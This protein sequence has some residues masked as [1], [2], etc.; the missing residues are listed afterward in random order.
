MMM[1]TAAAVAKS[2]SDTFLPNMVM[3]QGCL[4]ILI[5]SLTTPRLYPVDECS[6]QS[7]S[8]RSVDT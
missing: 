1:T 6:F 4:S 3:A 8:S 2:K 7:V 5:A